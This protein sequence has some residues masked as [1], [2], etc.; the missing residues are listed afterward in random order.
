M[1]TQTVKI[2][3]TKTQL[4]ILK[5]VSDAKALA[6]SQFELALTTIIGGHYE[7]G[8]LVEIE[9]DGTIVLE[10]PAGP[11]LVEAQAAEA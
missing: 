11:A 5:Q 6:E 10:L 7:A 4:A 9:K 8:K 2:T 3:P 1:L